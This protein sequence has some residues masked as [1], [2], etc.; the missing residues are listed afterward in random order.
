M[1]KLFML[2]LL[3]APLSVFG[4]NYVKMSERIVKRYNKEVAKPKKLYLSGSGGAMMNDIQRV[5]LNFQSCE[6][7]NINEARTLY[8]EMMEDFLSRMNENEKIRPYLHDYPFGV[9]NFDLMI[10]FEDSK[11]KITGDGHV[12]LLFIGRN[13]ELL[14]EAYDQQAGKFYTLHREPYVESLRIVRAK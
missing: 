5:I 6:L 8:V 1:N 9:D 12:A 13:Q 2:L 14:F 11:H 3:L 4:A 7:L 10:G